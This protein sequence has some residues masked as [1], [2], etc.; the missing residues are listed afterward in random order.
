MG[1]LNCTPDSFSDGGAFMSPA[2]AIDH[3]H[4]LL[5]AGADLVDVGGESTRPGASPV[6]PQIESTRVVPVIAEL[7]R[8]HPE[9]I[10]S[11][12]TAKA[13]VART[14]L[15]AGADVVNDVTAGADSALLEAVADAEAGI[16]LMHL[17]GTPRTMQL[18]TEYTDVVA[19]VH[20][21]LAGRA[22]A[23]V[24]AGIP[25]A[26]VWLDPGIGFGKSA[27]GNLT[28]LAA[29]PMLA[30]LGHPVVIGASRKSFIGRLTDA[31]VDGRLAGSL[32]CLL[33]AVGL[34][35]AVVRVHDVA[36]T[37]QF[38]TMASAVAEA[39]R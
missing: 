12:D 8:H 30:A 19:E 39:A 7:R 9:A 29:L 4:A 33:P 1:I 14:A 25:P 28:L 5:E 32:A 38:L 36:A 16:I 13:D 2:A 18:D 27:A 31:P 21:F 20:H 15:A 10:L 24:A 37:R 22:A 3:G 23:A 17:R 34:Q 11:V 35:H 26:A 6:T